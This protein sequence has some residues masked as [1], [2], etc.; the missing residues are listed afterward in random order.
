MA[1]LPRLVQDLVEFISLG[2]C[3]CND[4]TSI[5]WAAGDALQKPC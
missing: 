4:Y 2:T 5:S 3:L 1:E